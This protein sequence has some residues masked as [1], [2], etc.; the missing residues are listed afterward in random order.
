MI[1]LDYAASTPL[2]PK[3]KDKLLEAYALV[4]NPQSDQMVELKT[5]IKESKSKIAKYFNGDPNCI[6][7]TSGATE[8]ISTAIIG[9][10]RFYQRN[11]NHIITFKTEHPSV[12][13]ACSVLEK[14]GFDVS[15]LEVKSDGR[16]DYDLL[17][18]AITDKTILISVNGVC[19][20]TGLVQDL[21]PLQELK[22]EYGFLVHLDACQ[23]VGKVKMG[24]D[25]DYIS[26][27]S[28]KCYGPQGVGALY[29]QKNRHIKPII[30]GKDKVRSGT[31]PI[32]LIQLMGDAYALS[33]EDFEKNNKY[34]IGLRERFLKGLKGVEYTVQEGDVPSIINIRFHSADE[35]SIQKIRDKIYCQISSACSDGVSHVLLSRLPYL[36]AKQCIRFSLGIMTRNEDIDLAVSAIKKVFS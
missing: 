21:I 35:N 1:Y 14:E 20:E 31:M 6:Y 5:V 19:N 13:S 9:G 30:C 33:L 8:S 2:H 18:S 29:I 23:M 16:I 27:S 25:F 26:L 11:G 10:S 24:N 32:A 7:F 17:R 22:K 12:L 36:E 4:G 3:L 28:H 15:V 34:I